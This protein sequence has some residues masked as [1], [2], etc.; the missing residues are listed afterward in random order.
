MKNLA[1]AIVV[2][3]CAFSGLLSQDFG[4]RPINRTVN[5]RSMNVGVIPT[6]TTRFILMEDEPSFM[7]IGYGAMLAL[8][9]SIESDNMLN[10]GYMYL[11]GVSFHS[12]GYSTNFVVPYSYDYS[13]QTITDV[14]Y[15]STRIMFGAMYSAQSA[16]GNLG[17]QGTMHLDIEMM[18]SE[19]SGT[20]TDY[21][22]GSGTFSTPDETTTGSL[23]IG[24]G[25]NKYYD[26]GGIVLIP[27]IMAEVGIGRTMNVGAEYS[28]EPSTIPIVPTLCFMMEARF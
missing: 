16:T 27:G 4:Q 21:Y 19:L 2:C 6:V 8:D 17:F 3:C 18:S 10:A 9:Y 24:F 23:S 12:G 14:S 11:A 7:D 22:E 1:A 26:L 5:S 25:M 15:T 20:Y 28:Y 13:E